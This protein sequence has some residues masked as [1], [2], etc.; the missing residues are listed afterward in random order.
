MTEKR[1]VWELLL[2]DSVT[3]KL[4]PLNG[5]ADKLSTKFTGLQDK[6]SKTESAFKGAA[7]EIP[8]MSRGLDMLSNPM[9]LAGAGIAAVGA[10]L[11]KAGNLALDFETGMAKIN[12]TAQLG[13]GDLGKLQDRLQDI[14]SNSG[15]NFEQI[16]QAYE[17]IL[18]QTGNVNLSL[19]IGNFRP[20][21]PS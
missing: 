17:K 10:G 1:S 21:D 13:A 5:A 14:G 2:K 6:I 3:T 7:N 16:P 4:N 15:G 18:S 12:A 9:M 11:Y 20:S 19:N 8:G